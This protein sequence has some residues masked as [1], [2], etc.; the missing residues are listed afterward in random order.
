[1]ELG[2]NSVQLK[3]RHASI[4]TLEVV[5]IDI[6]RQGQAISSVRP[7]QLSISSIE[8]IRDICL[9]VM[10]CNKVREQKII[11]YT[12]YGDVCSSIDYVCHLYS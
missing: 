10:Y 3:Q 1:M 6:Y 5:N 2:I 4:V 7:T 11:K 9:N 12:S 8:E